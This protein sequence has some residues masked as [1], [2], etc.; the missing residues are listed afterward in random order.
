MSTFTLTEYEYSCTYW[1]PLSLL[2]H[3]PILIPC[4]P[5]SVPNSSTSPE[6]TSVNCVSLVE[7]LTPW[8]FGNQ[9]ATHEVRA[10]RKS[11]DL[12]SHLIRL[13]P[14]VVNMG[15]VWTVR[16]LQEKS[17]LSVVEDRVVSWHHLSI[18]K[19]ARIT[20]IRK[21]TFCKFTSTEKVE[22]F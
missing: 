9:M 16:V 17:L 19:Y 20:P 13:K 11:V 21:F 8:D 1:T 4:S 6:K 15:S 10:T 7:Q 3:F 18:V 2:T 14:L 12:K 5:T 22:S